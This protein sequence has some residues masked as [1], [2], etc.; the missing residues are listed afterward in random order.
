MRVIEGSVKTLTVLKEPGEREH[1][2]GRFFFTDRF[3]VFD[4][5]EMPDH[6]KNK[7]AS[8]CITGAYFFEKLEERGIKTHYRGVIENGR[9]IS[10]KEAKN[11]PREMEVELVR[12]IKPERKGNSYNYS[13]YKKLKGNFLIPLEVIYRNSLPPGSSVFK[14]F[15]DGSLKPEDIGLQSIPR[16]GET[17][18]SPIFDLSTKLESTDR[19]LT[20]LEAK[21][22]AGLTDGE[23][24]KMKKILQEVN[25]L[26]TE[27]VKK[28]NLL[29]E[30]GKIELAFNE[31]RD[32]M[33]VDVVGTMDEC[34]FSWN[35]LP[36]SKEIMRIYYRKTSWYEKVNEAKKK[37]SVNWKKLVKENPS[38]LP[39]ELLH[40]IENLYSSFANELT[41]RV[42]FPSTPPLSEVLKEIKNFIT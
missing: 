31:K 26:I 39:S 22:I 12:V 20:W 8:L 15:K 32:F 42:W 41:G 9:L 4:W 17:L 3:S 34:R 36:V 13:A 14:R 11:P 7:G 19:Y 1:G 5:G 24:E 21:E 6:I 35:G 30:D 25:S 38:P 33:V 16:E 40:A 27:E 28:L 2:R 23:I 29:N 18:P 37:D 10:L